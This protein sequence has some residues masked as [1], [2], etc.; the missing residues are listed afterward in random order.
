[1]EIARLGPIRRWEPGVG[2]A[3]GFVRVCFPGRRQTKSLPAS[4]SMRKVSVPFGFY[5]RLLPC[6]FQPLR[7]D[8]IKSSH[9]WLI[10]LES[11]TLKK[12]NW[13]SRGQANLTTLFN[14]GM[15]QKEQTILV[16]TVPRSSHFMD[17]WI[18]SNEKSQSQFVV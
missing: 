13:H 10:D 8:P 6:F 18:Y 16:T 1:M 14:L 12:V 15:D 9:G 11:R 4:C 17:G 2:F 3:G 5:S 7:K